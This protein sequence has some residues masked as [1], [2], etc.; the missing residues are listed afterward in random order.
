MT[1]NARYKDGYS[2]K[3]KSTP[4]DYHGCDAADYKNGFKPATGGKGMSP[5]A[6]SKD[7]GIGSGKTSAK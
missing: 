3:I 2:S 1:N 4:V 7:G 6:P 5:R